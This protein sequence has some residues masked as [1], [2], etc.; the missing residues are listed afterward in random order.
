MIESAAERDIRKVGKKTVGTNIPIISEEESRR[1]ADDFLVLIWH[2]R[3]AVI[4]REHEFLE[5]GGKMIFPL[6][7]FEI[8]SKE[9][10]N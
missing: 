1:R 7:N 5:S 9:K 2:F 10:N 3:D 4:K 6:P 8:V